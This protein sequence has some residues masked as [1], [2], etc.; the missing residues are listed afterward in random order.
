MDNVVI[1]GSSGH[2]KVVADIILAENR[3]N[4]VGFLD[5]DGD[6]AAAVLGLPVLGKD[7]DLPLL[8]AR[9]EVT[10]VIVG[11]GD[12]YSRA[13]VSTRIAG[14]LPE[15]KFFSAVHPHASIARD[16]AIGDGT[17]VMA[18]AVVN[19]GCKMKR[20]CIVNTGASLDHDST[21]LDFSS[22]APGVVTGGN[23][24]IGDHAAIGIGA[25]IA[26]GV[27]VGDHAV[28]GAGSTVLKDIARFSVAYG[29]PARFVRERAVGE[30]YL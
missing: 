22:L 6:T 30:K 13:A 4:L 3:L 7:T 17:V 18:G 12:N 19:A 26:H 25:V 9:H 16:V 20:G 23:C 5:R 24:V 15:V 28:V 21:M 1:I 2:A 14:E 27:T 11:I 10:G 8:L 29:S